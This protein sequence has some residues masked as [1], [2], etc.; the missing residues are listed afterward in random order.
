MC[1][2]AV[3]NNRGVW[4][5]AHHQHSDSFVNAK[6]TNVTPSARDDNETLPVAAFDSPLSQRASRRVLF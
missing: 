4:G 2:L 6:N 5:S 3:F 1:G